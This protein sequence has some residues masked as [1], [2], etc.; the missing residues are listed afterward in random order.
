MPNIPK[1]AS[2][3]STL[4]ILRD[5]YTFIYKRNLGPLKYF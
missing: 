5:G 1:N 2:L 4:D 3:D